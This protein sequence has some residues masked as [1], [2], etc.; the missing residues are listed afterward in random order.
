MIAIKNFKILV[1]S[2][3]H[4]TKAF[5]NAVLDYPAVPGYS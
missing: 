2:I 1:M 5:K 3:P 4:S